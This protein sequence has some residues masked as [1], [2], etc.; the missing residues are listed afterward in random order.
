MS[1][2]NTGGFEAY[3]THILTIKLWEWE[4]V[5]EQ[6]G[7]SISKFGPDQ[8]TCDAYN[9]AEDKIRFLKEAIKKLNND[10]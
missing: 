5:K 8:I 2:N 6:H 4:S 7:F 10:K 3:P 9:E 1:I